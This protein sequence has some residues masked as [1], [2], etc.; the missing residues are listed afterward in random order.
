MRDRIN[1]S[2]IVIARC[3]VPTHFAEAL[4]L[5]G[6]YRARLL[7]VVPRYRHEADRLARRL[8]TANP[9]ETDTILDELHSLPREEAWEDVIHNL[10]TTV[11]RNLILDTILSGSG[12]TASVVMGLKGTGSAAA[13][14]TQASHSGWSE[15]G[16]TNAPAYSGNRPT[17]SFS[18]AASGSKATSSDVSFTFTSGGTVA[19]CFININGSATKDSTTGTLLSAGDFIGGSKTVA[20][21]DVLNVSYTLQT[22]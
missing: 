15:V 3:A 4:P 13:G 10:V 21:T 7:R 9:I 17:P 11:G 20:S 18:A 19:G 1:F 16:G 22:I 8:A 6:I 2:D 5:H 14:D 12:F